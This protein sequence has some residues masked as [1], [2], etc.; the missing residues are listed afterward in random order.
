MSRD[1]SDRPIMCLVGIPTWW[2]VILSGGDVVEIR[3]DGM[4]ETDRYFSFVVLVEGQPRMEFE[5]AR[6]PREAVRSA[7]GGWPDRSAMT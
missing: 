3:A 5:L 7:D 6:F 2:R 4:K 1:I